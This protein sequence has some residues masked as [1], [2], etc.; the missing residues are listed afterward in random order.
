[1]KNHTTYR[2]TPV[3]DA[4][5][6]AEALGHGLNASLTFHCVRC[7]VNTAGIYEQGPEA[8]RTC[9]SCHSTLIFCPI[10]RQCI[11]TKERY[12][13]LICDGCGTNFVTESTTRY[14]V[15]KEHDSAEIVLSGIRATGS[16][17]LGNFF[18]AV[19][20]FVQFQGQHN[21]CMFFVADLHT[22]TTFSD[23][24]KIE[25]NTVGIAADYIAAGL[26]PNQSIIYA[27]SSVPEI[28]ELA[29]L[30]AMFQ[31]MGELTRI[32]TLKQL[33]KPVAGRVSE[34]V[35]SPV[36]L[37]VDAMDQMNTGMLVYPILMAADILGPQATM[38]PVGKDQVPN[39]ELA[40]ELARRV[41]NA[42]GPILT[43]PRYSTNPVVPGLGG[44]KMGKSSAD[45]S[46]LL[47]DSYDEIRTKY[48]K[49]GVT[50]TAKFRKSDKGRVANCPSVFPMYQILDGPGRFALQDEIRAGCES[51][52]LGC[53][54]CKSQLAKLLD[55]RIGAFREKRAEVG[56]D[57]DLVRDVLHFGGLKAREIIG[58]TVEKMREKLGIVRA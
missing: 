41:N 52:N 7:K 5:Q 37:S 35:N 48:Q 3:T 47:S 26:D 28:P 16:M 18:G 39:V 54:D 21:F 49:F 31:P 23:A 13:V 56:K 40:I 29:L 25:F 22:L 24:G 53:A 11:S 14:L 30:L 43:S 17:H 6:I 33:I 1:M 20:Q 4:G 38:I 58:P 42:L 12:K 2:L 44:G 51:G 9:P 8:P 50:D 27:Q 19:D 36:P 45:K 15:A 55:D 10:C 34:D 32:P 57:L 46:V